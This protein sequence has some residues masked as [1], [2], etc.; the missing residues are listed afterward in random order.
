MCH[1]A[2]LTQTLMLLAS[3]GHGLRGS[4]ALRCG[5]GRVS[6]G[7]QAIG[8]ADKLAPGPDCKPYLSPQF[9]EA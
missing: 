6:V 4:A 1:G 3:H 5:E 8:L 9:V 2:I 7:L